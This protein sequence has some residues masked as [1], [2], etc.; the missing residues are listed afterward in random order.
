MP[1]KKA[2]YRLFLASPGDVSKERAATKEEVEAFNR[3]HEDDR[4]H[5]EVILWEEH[6]TPATGRP[7]RVIF[8]N[9]KFEQT[10]LFVGIFWS[11]MGTPSGKI[12]P[13]TGKEYLSGA[14]EEIKEGLRLIDEGDSSA[15]R[16]SRDASSSS[17]PG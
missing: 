17:S 9:T 12:D 6:A 1:T 5:I 4:I 7:Q 10:D 8:E 15:A 2:H 11:R 16:I 3:L 13:I 14:M